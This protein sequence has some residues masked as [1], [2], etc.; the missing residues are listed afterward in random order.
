VD[1]VVV[2]TN[3]TKTI[4]GNNTITNAYRPSLIISKVYKTVPLKDAIFE[5]Y[6]GDSNGPTGAS[7]GSVTT[8][9]DGKGIFQYLLDG[10]YWLVETKPPTGY[11]WGDNI[12]PFTVSNGTI[13]GPSPY[14]PVP[15]EEVGTY[16]VTVQNQPT[17]ELPATGGFGRIPFIIGGLAMIMI[18][19]YLRKIN[20]YN[21]K[22]I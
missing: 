13:A 4:T 6:R 14:T 11:K 20:K 21:S 16:T 18:A 10:T 7:L 19:I 17:R 22:D 9:E 8:G 3:Y 5:L 1:E 12:G 2:P 15:N